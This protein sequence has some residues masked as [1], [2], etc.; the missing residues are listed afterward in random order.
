[1]RLFFKHLLRSIRGRPLQPIVLVLTMALSV[2]I[3]ACAISL[4]AR[5]GEEIEIGSR[6]EYG[7]ANLV[8]TLGS[9]STSRFMFEDEAREILGEADRKS[10]V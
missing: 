6:M 3:M 8:V 9:E 10:V 1:M 5:L 7:D 2:A 4:E